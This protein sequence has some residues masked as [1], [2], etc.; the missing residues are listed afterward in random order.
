MRVIASFVVGI[1]AGGVGQIRLQVGE[2]LV[3]KIAKAQDNKAIPEN[4]VAR[5]EEVL[6]ETLVV[7]RA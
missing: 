4:A 6:G 3:D 7:R 5:V 2:T 1:P